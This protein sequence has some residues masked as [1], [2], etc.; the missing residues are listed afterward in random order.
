[1]NVRRRSSGPCPCRGGFSLVEMVLAV[2]IAAFCLV[3]MLG[4]IPTGLNANKDSSGETAAANISR[5]IVSD[6]RATAKTTNTSRLYG[7]AFPSGSSAA[8]TNTVCFSEEGSTNSPDS[9]LSRY[10]ATVILTSNSPTPTVNVLIRV[11]WPAAANP[12]AAP[13]WYEA[14]TAIDRRYP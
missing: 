9:P 14:A 12:S 6:L 8:N 3:V 13:G 4:L 7:I 5:N 11:T 10:K 2:G 1:M